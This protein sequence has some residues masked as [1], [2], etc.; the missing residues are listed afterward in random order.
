MVF[1][2]I[3]YMPIH[4]ILFPSNLMETPPDIVIAQ[5]AFQG[6]INAIIS[7]LGFGYA[8]RALGATITSMCVAIVPAAVAVLAL[9]LLDEPLTALTIGGVAFVII[10]MLSTAL[11][12]RKKQEADT[13]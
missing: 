5:G 8:A 6:L 11:P 3:I 10:G 13:G 2:L 4:L 12:S 7:T 1:S 9:I